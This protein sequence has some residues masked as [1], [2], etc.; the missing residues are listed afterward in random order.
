MPAGWG[1]ITAT[2]V[3]LTADGTVSDS[4][5]LSIPVRNPRVEVT[6]P[7]P[8]DVDGGAVGGV[9]VPDQFGF[10]AYDLSAGPA[11]TQAD[12]RFGV[13]GN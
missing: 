13:A 5:E 9:G 2:A 3:S 8:L 12:Y 1:D 4:S 7:W 11:T 6:N 10:S